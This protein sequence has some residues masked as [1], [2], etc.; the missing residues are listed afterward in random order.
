MESSIGGHIDSVG[1]ALLLTGAYFSE[2]DRLWM[3]AI[4]LTLAAGIKLAPLVLIV[5]IFR[6]NRK[7]FWFLVCA[8]FI[9]CLWSAMQYATYPK[10]LVAFAHKWRGNDGL[11]G[12][13]YYLAEIG[14]PA[15]SETIRNSSSL[16]MIV[17]ML[18]GGD[19]VNPLTDSQL[20]F[21]LSKIC[22]LFILGLAT[23]WAFIKCHSI[24]SAWWFF[25]GVLLLISPM[26][27]PWYLVWVL[28]IC[29]LYS[30][31]GAKRFAQAFIIWG[32]VC[33]LAYLPRPDYLETGIW[34][35][36]PWIKL[37][38]YSPVW[39]LL[40]IAIFGHIRTN[41]IQAKRD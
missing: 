36:Q 27:H 1:I 17:H 12:I 9:F 34:T 30:R 37:I 31:E 38:E 15:F 18:V 7:L 20:A 8:I 19:P 35:E 29:C 23:F 25:M 40:I 13:I 4:S 16:T 41:R 28:P 39:T 14:I 11:F 32:L 33:W 5:F 24:L 6:Q 21:A 2:R 3:A 26:V 22:V 10:G